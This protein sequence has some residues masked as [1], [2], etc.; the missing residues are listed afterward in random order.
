MKTAYVMGERGNLGRS[1]LSHW[2]RGVKLVSY[3]DFTR[4]GVDY[5]FVASAG[6][7]SFDFI[8]KHQVYAKKVIDFSGSTKSAALSGHSEISYGLNPW[9]DKDKK[10][11]SLPGCSSWG[12]VSSLLPLQDVLPDVVFADVKFSQ[13]ALQHDSPH[14]LASLQ[15]QNVYTFNHY[16]QYEINQA[17]KKPNLVQ[18]APSLINVPSGLSINLFFKPLENINYIENFKKNKSCNYVILSP[19]IPNLNSAIA[20]DKIYFFISQNLYGVN[21]NIVLDNLVNSRFWQYL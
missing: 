21:I 8:L 14:N 17:L 10:I 1:I 16:H 9:Y 19:N 3:H 2:P 7:K 6:N 15:I 20:S 11:I 4:F 18:M 5:L 12:I 13:S